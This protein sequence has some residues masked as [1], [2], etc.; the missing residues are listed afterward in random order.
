MKLPIWIRKDQ[1]HGEETP[2]DLY[3]QYKWEPKLSENGNYSFK[4]IAY[5]SND[6]SYESER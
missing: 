4:A 2:I 3:G 5:D 1:Y 6:Q